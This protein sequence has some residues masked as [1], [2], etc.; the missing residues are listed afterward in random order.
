MWC[1]VIIKWTFRQ[2]I[3]MKV[4]LQIQDMKGKISPLMPQILNL[5]GGKNN[6]VHIRQPQALNKEK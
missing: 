4:M 5:I 6:L 1:P 3:D 2:G